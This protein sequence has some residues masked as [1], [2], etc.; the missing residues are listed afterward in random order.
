VPVTNSSNLHLAGSGCLGE[1]L[2]ELPLAVRELLGHDDA[3][4]REQIPLPAAG[5]RESAPPQSDLASRGGAG[6]D[7]HPHLSGG[8]LDVRLAPQY[9]LRRE[10]RNR[11]LDVRAL[12]L[13]TR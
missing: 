12:D 2:V 1:L 7:A 5:L 6:R 3:D 11:G 4:L 9:G 13:E 10:D 8:G